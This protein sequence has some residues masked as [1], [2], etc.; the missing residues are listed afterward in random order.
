MHHLLPLRRYSPEN[1]K[2]CL[3]AAEP[4]NY[5]EKIIKTGGAKEDL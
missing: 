2:P 5:N 3:P 4:V 1:S